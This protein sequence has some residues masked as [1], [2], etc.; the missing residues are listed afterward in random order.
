MPACVP[1]LVPALVPIPLPALIPAPVP[2][3]VSATMP[4]LI[5][6]L[7]S[8]TVSLFCHALVSCR[9]ILAL[10]LLLLSMFG[11]PLFLGSS[12]LRIFKWSLSDE[13]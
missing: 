9:R 7:G 6:C 10:L 12:T 8:S 13:S 5:F 2:A 1:A 11:S 4:A 3:F